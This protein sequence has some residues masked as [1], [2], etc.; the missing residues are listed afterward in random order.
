MHIRDIIAA[1]YDPLGCVAA[2]RF[3]SQDQNRHRPYLAHYSI[4]DMSFI[5]SFELVA[6]NQYDIHLPE[7][8]PS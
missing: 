2:W 5:Q 6:V 3:K 7:G 8:G 4:A 1:R